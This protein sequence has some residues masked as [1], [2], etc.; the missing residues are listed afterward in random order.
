MIGDYDIDHRLIFVLVNSSAAPVRKF[1]NFVF[2]NYFLE[3]KKRYI[4]VKTSF[5]Q[6]KKIT[7][8]FVILSWECYGDSNHFVIGGLD[9]T[10]TYF[11]ERGALCHAPFFSIA[12]HESKK[13]R[14]YV[15][16]LTFE[17]F[18][19]LSA[20][21]AELKTVKIKLILL[22]FNNAKV[23]VGCRKRNQN[24][25]VW[26]KYVGYRNSNFPAKNALRV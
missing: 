10:L 23:D 13:N 7:I 22:V 11:E 15:P 12:L 20:C 3:F 24:H 18:D 6:T 19:S 4:I 5:L 9:V 2:P 1:E 16:E 21:R 8:K 25:W 17:I 14:F 26:L